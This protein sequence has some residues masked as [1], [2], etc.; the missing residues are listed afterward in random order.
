MNR[1][2]NDLINELKDQGIFEN[3]DRLFEAFSSTDRIHFVRSD[4][5]DSAYY[6][7]P[8]YIG[9]GQTIS[10]PYT[11]AFM[12]S[13]L[14]VKKGNKVLEIG[15][16]SGWQTVILSKLVSTR[17]KVIA[18]ELIPELKTFGDANIDKYC[19]NNI[20]TLLAE[21]HELG[22]PSEGKYDR[23]ISGASAEDIPEKLIDQ[24]DDNGI[25]VIPVNQSIYKIIMINK[26]PKIMKYPGFV[27]VPLIQK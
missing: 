26:K 14:N 6:N 13:L 2:Y 19:V 1:T 11:V 8:L 4:D 23:I 21:P 10:Q 20:E 18:V 9:F 22:Y 25:M 15:Y 3:E 7:S 12:L 17:G 27:F 24:L 5:K 16:G